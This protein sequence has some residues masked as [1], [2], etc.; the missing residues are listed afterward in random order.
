[1]KEKRYYVNE[2]YPAETWESI[3]GLTSETARRILNDE[4]Y[5]E[6]RKERDAQDKA[7][8]ERVDAYSRTH[9]FPGC[10]GDPLTDC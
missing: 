1:M 5:A 10:Y 7:Y 8:R 4:E 3:L 6:W 2:E 9:Y